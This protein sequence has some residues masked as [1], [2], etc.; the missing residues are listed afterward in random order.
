MI[1][2]VEVRTGVE[3]N[4]HVD[5]TGIDVEGVPDCR[6]E[7]IEPTHGQL[8]AQVFDLVPLRRDHLVHGSYLLKAFCLTADE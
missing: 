8:T 4:E 7:N 2:I 3:L 1:E 5:V 6:A